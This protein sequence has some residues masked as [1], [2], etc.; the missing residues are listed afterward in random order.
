MERTC[1][2]PVGEIKEKETF[3]LKSNLADIEEIELI[4]KSTDIDL[5]LG[6]GPV[7]KQENGA[8]MSTSADLK[9][10]NC[11]WDQLDVNDKSIMRQDDD[12]LD[13]KEI[14]FDDL[15]LQTGQIEVEDQIF[16]LKEQYKNLEKENRELRKE[17]ALAKDEVRQMKG[18]AEIW[19][20]QT[21]AGA[22]E[23]EHISLQ[24]QDN[25]LLSSLDHILF[26][27]QKQVYL[28]GGIHNNLGYQQENKSA[29]EENNRLSANLTN[30]DF[31]DSPD[32]Y[33]SVQRTNK[34]LNGVH[35][36]HEDSILQLEEN[37]IRISENQDVK[38]NESKKM[39]KSC[40]KTVPNKPQS[41][42]HD[43]ISK[44]LKNLRNGHRKSSEHTPRGQKQRNSPGTHDKIKTE[45]KTQCKYIKN[46]EKNNE[47]GGQQPKS[48][49][50]EKLTRS[51]S[52][53]DADSGSE[54]ENISGGS[55]A[56]LRKLQPR[57][58]LDLK[59]NYEYKPKRTGVTPL[60][61]CVS[62]IPTWDSS[63]P[64][65][66]TPSSAL[67]PS[68]SLHNLETRN[69]TEVLI[70]T[71]APPSGHKVRPPVYSPISPPVKSSRITNQYTSPIF[72]TNLC[73]EFCKQ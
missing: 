36:E 34:G 46:N 11:R 22:R 26:E 16:M 64:P 52:G 37:C 55:L 33:N 27:K 44:N 57:L 7:G 24:L 63:F 19:R 62:T 50:A 13:V 30:E 21:E 70:P 69:F 17:L 39:M 29:D 65:T 73:V 41:P 23:D 20:T 66:P 9:V 42:S 14:I 54:K 43:A 10:E 2:Q 59:Q 28:L 51:K 38:S 40:N 48:V 3:I 1:L 12:I 56:S 4:C 49:S 47:S 71:L 60:S 25:F 15:P 68:L 32:M 8:N 67:R 58:K 72:K 61:C 6:F 5:H 18:E 53:Q 45:E 35:C 31:V